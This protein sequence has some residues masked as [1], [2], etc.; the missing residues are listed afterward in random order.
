MVPEHAPDSVPYEGADEGFV[1]IARLFAQNH[2][3][4]QGGIGLVGL[5]LPFRLGFRDGFLP[6][7][8]GLFLVGFQL[9]RV[10]LAV[11]LN[12]AL[13]LFIRVEGSLTQPSSRG[14]PAYGP[15]D[16][17]YGHIELFPQP[18][19][20]GEEQRREAVGFIGRR[21]L[22]PSL[23]ARQADLGIG[24]GREQLRQ[25]FVVFGIASSASGHV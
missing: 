19:A 21:L 22:P 7:G 5:L 23:G 14:G 6:S 11:L 8:E 3:W 18:D 15:N 17:P 2:S 20:K 1:Q 4:S 25:F 16:Q 9:L 10:D 13:R 24:R 12:Q